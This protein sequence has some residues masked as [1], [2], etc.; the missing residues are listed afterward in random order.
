LII[1]WA[2]PRVCP[3][4]PISLSFFF[5]SYFGQFPQNP[6]ALG[7]KEEKI[8]SSSSSTAVI[9]ETQGE[10]VVGRAN[11]SL[12]QLLEL[13]KVGTLLR[14]A[15]GRGTCNRDRFFQRYQLI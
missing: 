12:E 8:S 1:I 14:A 6:S 9:Q 2:E 11:I 5:S 10:R 15:A 3:C 7:V 13:E 4:L